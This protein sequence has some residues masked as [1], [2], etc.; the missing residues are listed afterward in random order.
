MGLLLIPRRTDIAQTACRAFGLAGGADGA[1]LSDDIHVQS[2]NRIAV[3]AKQFLQHALSGFCRGASRHQTQAPADA[4]D[5]CV[6]WHRRASEAKQ[7]HA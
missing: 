5:M 3:V 1:T 7:Q 6:Y 2:V 4:M